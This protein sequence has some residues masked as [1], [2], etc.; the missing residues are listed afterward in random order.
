MWHSTQ[1][2]PASSGQTT[3]QDSERINGPDQLL[4]HLGFAGEADQIRIR[5]IRVQ[6]VL[7]GSFGE[8]VTRR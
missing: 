4:R 6:D 5:F 3:P 1:L 7:A 8:V 2:P